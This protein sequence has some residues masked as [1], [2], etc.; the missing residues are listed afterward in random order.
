MRTLAAG[1]AERLRALLRGPV[2]TGVSLAP[3]T[4]FNIGGPAALVASPAD[5]A[6]LGRALIFAGEEGLPVH[7]LA[8]GSN[9]L[10]R[11]GGVR[12]LVIRPTAFQEL[13]REGTGVRAGAGVRIGRLLAF[14]V[15]QGL[16]GLEMLSGVPGTVGGA[17]WGNAGAWGG[18]IG[19][20]VRDLELVTPA[21]ERRVLERAAIPF[22]YRSSGLPTGA[23]VTAGCFDLAAGVPTEIRR[24]ISGY[25]VQRNARQPV[26]FRSAGSIFKNPPGDHAGRLVEAAGLKGHQIGNA[27]ISEQHGNFIV[28]LGG[29]TAADV[30]ALIRLAQ[31]RVR[32]TS[33]IA[34]ELEIRVIGDDRRS[35]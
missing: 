20:A 5:A 24:R 18:A 17:L 29:A 12:G 16:A 1:P 33:G 28:N 7:V 15:S 22:R 11:D 35:A 30:L 25:L 4:S 32:E 13:R 31:D 34:L 19:D 10:V 2:A 14:C 8:G 26:R 23:V 21:G 9:T 27:M 3:L 6:D